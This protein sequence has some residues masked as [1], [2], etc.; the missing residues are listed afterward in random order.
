MWTFESMHLANDWQETCDQ[1]ETI[2]EAAYQAG[3]W[4]VSCQ[5]AGYTAAV[6]LK[7]KA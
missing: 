6:R 2:E 5:R 7:E 4:M 3:L 1:F